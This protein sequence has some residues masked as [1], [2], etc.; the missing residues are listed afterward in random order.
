[1]FLFCFF[2]FVIL[3]IKVLSQISRAEREKSKN[4]IKKLPYPNRIDEIGILGNDINNIAKENT[5]IQRFASTEE[6]AN[7]FL[8]LSSNCASYCVGST[9]YVDGGMLKVI[10]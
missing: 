2:D 10:K 7:I 5:P 6:I 3:P 4:K 8:F 1:M 9:Y